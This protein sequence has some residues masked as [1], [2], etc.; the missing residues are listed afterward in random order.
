MVGNS[1]TTVQWVTSAAAVQTNTAA[2]AVE[3]K[4]AMAGG[5]EIKTGATIIIMTAVTI[6]AGIVAGIIMGAVAGAGITEITTAGTK[7]A[8]EIIKAQKIIKKISKK[9]FFLT[10]IFHHAI[11]FLSSPP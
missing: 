5:T 8:A 10:S 6:A 7:T 4:A 2:E 3:G 1:A 11:Y 9:N